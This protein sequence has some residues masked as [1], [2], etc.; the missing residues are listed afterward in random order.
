MIHPNAEMRPSASCLIQNKLLSTKTK[1][2]LRREPDGE[3]HKNEDG[4]NG[5]ND[6]DMN[7]GISKNFSG[8]QLRPTPTRMS[9]RVIGKKV[10]RSHSTIF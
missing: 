4:K 1:V 9:S 2:Q 6:I 8:Y 5:P 3:K 7:D 10:N